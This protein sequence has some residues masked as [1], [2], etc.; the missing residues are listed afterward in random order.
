MCAQG[1]HE[2]IDVKMSETQ[3]DVYG[4]RAGY[5]PPITCL[6]VNWNNVQGDAI[7]FTDTDEHGYCGKKIFDKI[8]KQ[9]NHI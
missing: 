3:P 6:I 9:C 8:R 4:P 1:R 7:K 5:C 2:N